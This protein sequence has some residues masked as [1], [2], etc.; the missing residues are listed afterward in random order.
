MKKVLFVNGGNGGF[1]NNFREASKEK[2][3]ECVSIRAA[4]SF[5]V[6]DND[7][8]KFFHLGE[9]IDLKSF[10]YCFIRVKSLKAHMTAL[11]SYLLESY[12]VPYNDKNNIEH[13]QNDEKITQ[14]VRFG[15]MG[16]PIPKSIIFSHKSYEKN[17]EIIQK[18]ITYPCVLKTNGSKGNAVWKISNQEDLESKMAEITHELILVQELIENSYDVRA[19]IFEGIFLGAIKR[20]SQDGFYNNVAK[21]GRV[22]Q[23]ELSDE[24]FELT[25]KAMSA[26]NLDFG[27]ADFIRTDKGI[28][29][30]EINKGPQVS[31]LEE[32]TGY[33]IPEKILNI[34]SDKYL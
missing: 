28:V 21:G 25:K 1:G 11:L 6:I 27:G 33:N 10:A 20:F 30:F 29:F 22:E 3:I 15:R 16:I 9:E 2:D 18:Y 5:I 7:G 34:I 17:K 19:L 8:C 12:G 26:I 32:A 13:T 14:M 23:T 24:E 4:H 31:G